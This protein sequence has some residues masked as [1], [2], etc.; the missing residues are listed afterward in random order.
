M[1]VF[2]EVLL[3]LHVGQGG[4]RLSFRRLLGGFL[5]SS[6]RCQ[7]TTPEDGQHPVKPDRFGQ[8][9]PKTHDWTIF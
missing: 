9:P 6:I 3:L 8:N 7:K 5:V 4:L 2:H 1:S